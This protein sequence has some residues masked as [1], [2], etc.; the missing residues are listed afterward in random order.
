MKAHSA[1]VV[2]GVVALLFVWGNLA[3]VHADL[4]ITNGDFQGTEFFDANTTGTAEG[5]VTNAYFTANGNGWYSTSN[6]TQWDLSANGGPA[7]AGDAYGQKD[8]RYS[9]P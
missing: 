5:I 9:P 7:G 2:A 1:I 8:Y 4:M 6:G 3:Q